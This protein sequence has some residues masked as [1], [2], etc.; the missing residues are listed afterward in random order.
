MNKINNLNFLKNSWIFA[1]GLLLVGVFSGCKKPEEFVG[2]EFIEAP[3]DLAVLSFDGPS[4]PVDFTKDS[5]GLTGELS[6]RVS[7]YVTF[8]GLESGAVKSFEGLSQSIDPSQFKWG[9]E[10]DPTKSIKFFKKGEPVLVEI[11]FLKSNLVSR[12]TITIGETKIFNGDVLFE[13]FDQKSYNNFPVYLTFGEN[14]KEGFK[15][16][17]I[18]EF[19][20]VVQGEGSWMLSGA[21]NDNTY[22]IGGTRSMKADGNSEY[23]EFKSLNP[24]SVY[25]NMYI[26]GD[27]NITT[28]VA[29]AVAED[30]DLD[31]TYEDATDDVWEYPFK[32]N[33]T[34]WKLVSFR[35]SDFAV[36]ASAA[37]GGSGNKKRQLD[38]VKRITLN[39][40]SDPPG[41]PASYIVDFPIITYGGPFDPSK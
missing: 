13:G 36:S 10:H 2:K 5:V 18:T 12:D 9:G 16:T 40:L 11:S 39:L 14:A 19:D 23:F 31:K 37:Y 41:N 3:S 4:V 17:P 20:K 1:S 25:F 15:G 32:L 33:W 28:R 26:Y 35:Y 38:R 21:D 34:G 24:D 29:L 30:D 7:W 8:T 27:G 22:F 6:H